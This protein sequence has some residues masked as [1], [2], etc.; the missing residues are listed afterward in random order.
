MRR[1]NILIINYVFPPYPGIG[2]RRWAKFAKYLHK[3]EHNVYVIAA[4][5][6]FETTSTFIDDIKEL[7]KKNL[8]YLHP[9]YPTILLK[10]PRSIID[11]LSYNFWCKFLPL[12]S[13]GNFI[14][15]TNLWSRFWKNSIRSI[16]QNNA[17]D[18]II[19]SGPDFHISYEISKIKKKEFPHIHL[20]VDYRDEWTFNDVHGFGIISDKRKQVEFEKEK[21]VC[22]NADAVISCHQKVLDYLNGRYK[23]K[24]SCLIPHGFDKD[25]FSG[26]SIDPLFNKK[27]ENINLSFFGTMEPYTELFFEQL[28][29]ALT[30]IKQYNTDIYDKLR[31]KFYL[32]ST[33][34]YSEYIKNH[35]SLFEFQYNLSSTTLFRKL[36]GTNFVLLFLPTWIKDYFTT[37]FPEI[38]Y[39]KKPIILYSD[40]GKI[41]EFIQQHNIGVHLP[42][43]DFYETFVNALSN[44][45]QFS[46]DNFN[47]NEWDYSHITDKLID[48][49]HDLKLI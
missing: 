36:V 32:I 31:F 21:F 9:M 44:P 11:K 39:L 49:I 29:M 46:Y 25:D 37:K 8:F 47:L 45:H 43:E 22:E 17:I 7:P 26:I 48:L 2:G 27:S 35:I 15:R 28:D 34:Q 40:E 10:Q 13:K 6:P 42:K 3:K 24:Y 38:F 23:I 12:F 1:K 20:I 41:S 4:K 19:V 16:I 33:F 14:D 5:N 18:V 30:K